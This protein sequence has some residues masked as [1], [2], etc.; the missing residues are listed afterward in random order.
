MTCLQSLVEEGVERGLY[1]GASY[2]VL[3]LPGDVLA[4][5]VAGRAQEAPD[6]PVTPETVWDLA[7]L[8]KPL[9]TATS[10][11]ILAQE[12]R[13][14]L[15]EEIAR[16]LPG[17]S[18]ALVGITVRHCLTHTSGLKPWE[19]LH[20][21]NLERAE[22]LS[23]VRAAERSRPP[24][25]G[26]AY[27]DLGYILLG[28]LVE[29]ISGQTVAE[30][31][32]ERVFEPLGMAHTCY[33]PPPEWKPRLAATRCLDR[34]SV[35]LGEVHD[36]NCG[37]L[38]GVAGHAGLFGTL[39]DLLTYAQMLLGEGTLGGMRVLAPLAAR[40]MMRNQNPPGI[41]GHTLGWFARPSGYLPAGDFLPE[42]TFGHTGFTGTSLL[43]SPSLGLAVALLTNRVYYAGDAGDFLQFRRRFH[44]AVGGIVA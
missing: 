25:A 27:S 16:L 31:A 10:V 8:T 44:N 38:G 42:D 40:Q 1:L 28:E 2:A 21:Q 41:N 13:L 43:L 17:E 20:S 9:A 14:H 39:G 24:G 23:R 15:G 4:T 12:G 22:V 18:P 7:S 34:G 32:R 6:V 11:L 19:K 33:L 26:Y 29:A 35:L 3:R 30:F 5:G 36:G 37:A